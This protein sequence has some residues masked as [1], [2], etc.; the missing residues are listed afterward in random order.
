M[1]SYYKETKKK[2]KKKSRNQKRKGLPTLFRKLW[3]HEFAFALTQSFMLK[4][5]ALF[6]FFHIFYKHYKISH[7]IKSKL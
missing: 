6:G 4:T 5:R 1:Q 7:S 2:E 3:L